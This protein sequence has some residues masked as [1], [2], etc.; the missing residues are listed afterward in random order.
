MKS[1][2][3]TTTETTVDGGTEYLGCYEDC[4][5]RTLQPRSGH[6]EYFLYNTGLS[7]EVCA[8]KCKSYGYKYMGLQYAKECF[9]RDNFVTQESRKVFISEREHKW[10]RLPTST[11]IISAT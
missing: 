8:A 11:K 5:P 7:K 1:K 6:P 9:C 10:I 4:R 3:P 2:V